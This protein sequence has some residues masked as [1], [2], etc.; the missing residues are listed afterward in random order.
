MIDKRIENEIAHGKHLKEVWEGTFWYWET[1]AGKL[2]W[3]RRLEMLTAHITPGMKV[4]EIGCGVGYFSK[5]IAKSGVHIT[6][7][8]ISSD[9]LNIAR[10]KIKNGNIEFR[11]QNAYDLSF[12]ENTFDTIV[13]S[14][15][16]HHLDVH[17][18]LKEF[19][20][21]LK[22]KGTLYFTEPNMINP[23]IFLERYTALF[24]YLIQKSP[25][26]TAF[27]RNRLRKD[28]LK[29]GFTNIQITPFDFLH[30]LTPQM[31]I[32]AVKALGN[33]LERTPLVKE[34]AGSLYIRANKL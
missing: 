8:D 17:R 31:F 16:L 1:A 6:A 11:V 2:R 7:I 29:Y 10:E 15:T 33:C 13:G 12:P 18:A 20:R 24:G 32:P 30:P 9:L 21:V 4:L 27:I 26:E 25:D 5:E 22:P 34:I 14:S 28:L 19:Y 3:K 23:Q